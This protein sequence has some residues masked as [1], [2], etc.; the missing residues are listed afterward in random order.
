VLDPLVHQATRLRILAMLHKN[1][2]V[3]AKRLREAIGLTEGNFGAHLAKLE[4]GGYVESRPALTPGGFETHCRLT[5]T[6]TRALLAY[7]AELRSLLD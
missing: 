7:L 5:D 2:D 3:S 1:R 4:A 6:G